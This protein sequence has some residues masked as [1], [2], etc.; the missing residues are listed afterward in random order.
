[1]T[2]SDGYFEARGL[3]RF[4]LQ[5]ILK[6]DGDP[7]EAIEGLIQQLMK[8][9]AE[10]CFKDAQQLEPGITREEY[11]AGLDETVDKIKHLYFS[12]KGYRRPRLVKV[13]DGKEVS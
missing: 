9:E 5:E 1:M 13:T 2:F 4:R 6:Q 11:E 8:E 3:I 12:E 10:D 7:R